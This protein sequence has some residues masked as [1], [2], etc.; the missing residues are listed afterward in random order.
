MLL[1]ESF[2][3]RTLATL[4]IGGLL[5][6]GGAA[7]RHE[8]PRIDVPIEV[9][10][11]PATTA[12]ELALGFTFVADG[13]TWLALDHVGSA[14]VPAHDAARVVEDDYVD[15]AIANLSAPRE[16]LG[17]EVTLDGGCRESL[18]DFALISRVSGSPAYAGDADEHWTAESILA[19]G[20]VTIAARLTHCK[21]A[22][23]STLPFHHLEAV[24]QDALREHAERVLLH[25]D[26]AGKAKAD[27][28]QMGESRTWTHDAK[29]DT[30][31]VRDSRG[32]TWISAQAHTD[33]IGC[34]EPSANFW[35]LFRVDPDG[36]FEQVALRELDD[37]SSIDGMI[38]V[39]GQIVLL[40]HSLL[41][42]GPISLDIHGEQRE[43]STLP[44]FG[45]PC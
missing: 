15:A 35:G 30:I 2:S 6:L 3:V 5:L 33:G 12:P 40:A 1:H 45:C 11:L 42:D 17:R 36:S 8:A 44:Y 14:D 38:E 9:G 23:A 25:S 19:H 21:G 37:V 39:G 22:F 27:W 16:W 4:G 7:A 24:D 10:E 20:D 31:V 28:K 43:S 13:S 41:P 29:I 26:F 34:G 18:H 32:T